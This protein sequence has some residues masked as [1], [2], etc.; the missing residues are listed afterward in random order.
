MDSGKWTPVISHRSKQFYPLSNPTGVYLRLDYCVFLQ[1][2]DFFCLLL[3]ISSCLFHLFFASPVS[4][5][6]ASFS[7]CSLL[8]KPVTARIHIVT[9]HYMTSGIHLCDAIFCVHILQFI[10]VSVYIG[11]CLLWMWK[12]CF[13]YSKVKAF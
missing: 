4:E 12:L 6:V 11:S 9:S 2:R 3:W 5:V 10:N 13:V 1:W 7:N 8:A